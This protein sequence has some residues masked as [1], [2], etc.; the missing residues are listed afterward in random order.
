MAHC[1]RKAAVGTSDIADYRETVLSLQEEVESA[2]R[3]YYDT[4]SNLSYAAFVLDK[5]GKIKYVNN[6]AADLLALAKPDI[7][8]QEFDRQILSRFSLSLAHELLSAA[9]GALCLGVTSRKV[10]LGGMLG[11]DRFVGELTVGSLRDKQDGLRG[12]VLL[13]EEKTQMVLMEENLSK[14]SLLDRAGA[15]AVGASHQLR[16]YLQ[17]VRSI[18]QLMEFK[19][20]D[21]SVFR[22]YSSMVY[23][24]LDGANKILT[25]L[26]HISHWQDLRLVPLSVNELCHEVVQLMQ[27]VL[28]NRDIIIEEEYCEEIPHLIL[29]Y[30]R[31]KQVLVNLISNGID[32]LQGS[33]T[34]HVM[35]K[36]DFLLNQGEICIIDN[37]IGMNEDT[38]KKIR[39]PFYTT[40]E[41]GSGVGL[42]VCRRMLADQG[43]YLKIESV[44]GKGSN[45]TIILPEATSKNCPKPFLSLE[46]VE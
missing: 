10:V 44:P 18:F 40:K 33:G 27:V 2:V 22:E 25:Q 9:Y 17:S 46:R 35:T 5:A 37:G 6:C 16:N 28:T 43:G 29:D 8:G 15:V 38:L 23:E 31:M 14:T 32:A 1:N 34:I 41:K 12:A 36:Y 4:L 20:R 21:D 24:E 42:V 19:R 3:F 11:D 30:F 26:L 7:I 39:A 13:L 45:F